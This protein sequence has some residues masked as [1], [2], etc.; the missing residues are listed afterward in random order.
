MLT[1]AQEARRSASA[2][3]LLP[4]DRRVGVTRLMLTDFR[5]YCEA[6]LAL[7]TEP[8]VLTGPNG[9]GKTNLLEAVSFL[10]PGRGLRGARSTEI[11]R[12]NM[13][14]RRDNT[15]D[16]ATRVGLLQ[17]QWLPVAARCESEPAATLPMA[18][19]GSCA[20]TANR[21]VAKPHLPSASAWYG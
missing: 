4:G 15:V 16:V 17:R 14:A 9:V 2:A 11:D 1:E 19:S 21:H 5:N 6:R 18:T 20:S 7:G 3:A 8:V 10:A 13:A 12:R